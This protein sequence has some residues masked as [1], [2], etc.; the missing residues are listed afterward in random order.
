MAN[1]GLILGI[2]LP[3]SLT[4]LSLLVWLLIWYLNARNHR[5]ALEY[6]ASRMRSQPMQ[7]TFAVPQTPVEIYT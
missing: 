5:R 1:V 3:I 7:M 4:I 6:Q 2:V